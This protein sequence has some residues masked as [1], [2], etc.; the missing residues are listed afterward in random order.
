M[1][2]ITDVW[3]FMSVIIS[4]DS[5]GA[6]VSGGGGVY[7]WIEEKRARLEDLLGMELFMKGL[8]CK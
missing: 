2:S 6:V 7:G 4:T 8:L 1:P 5:D 3:C